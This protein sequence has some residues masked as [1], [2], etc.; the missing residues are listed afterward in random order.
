M[1]LLREWE[2]SVGT[3]KKKGMRKKVVVHP[4]TRQGKGRIQRKNRDKV[5]PKVWGER[6]RAVSCCRRRVMGEDTQAREK[7]NLESFE[8]LMCHKV[9]HGNFPKK[10]HITRLSLPSPPTSAPLSVSKHSF[11]APFSFSFSF[12]DHSSLTH[13]YDPSCLPLLKP[14]LTTHCL[15]CIPP[16]TMHPPSSCVTFALAALQCHVIATLVMSPLRHT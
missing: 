5:H 16:S 9:N 8:S 12:S 13:I 4:K 10:C 1:Y 14:P 15:C 11:G 3:R 6:E 2:W 7:H